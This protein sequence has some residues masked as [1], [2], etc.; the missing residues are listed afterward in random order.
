MSPSELD[1]IVH[2]VVDLALIGAAW[3]VLFFGKVR[4]SSPAAQ[5]AATRPGRG[6]ATLPGQPGTDD[7]KPALRSAV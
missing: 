7:E 3:S 5:K 1:I 6:A 2:G 4:L